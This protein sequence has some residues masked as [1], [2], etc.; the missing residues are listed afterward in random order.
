MYTIFRHTI[1]ILRIC[2]SSHKYKAFKTYIKVKNTSREH[3]ELEHLRVERDLRNFLG[4]RES[5]ELNI[6]SLLLSL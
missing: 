6:T 5:K 1:R 4:K 3:H 2:S